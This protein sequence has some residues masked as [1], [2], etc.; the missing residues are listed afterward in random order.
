MPLYQ[1]VTSGVDLDRAQRDRLAQGITAIHQ[2]ETRAP[3]PF[4]RVVFEPMPLGVVY[5][6]G[7]VSPVVVLNGAIRSGRSESTRHRIMQSCYTLVAD[8]TGAPADQIFV[9]VTDTAN[10]RH[11]EAGMVLP[12]PRAEA[13]D[14]W[15]RQLQEL[16]PGKYDD[17]R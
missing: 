17:Y 13:E 8:V 14:A 11:M 1:V 9:A 15:M 3:E 10:S 16:F 2:A 7:E 6:D 4:V 5:T 12:E